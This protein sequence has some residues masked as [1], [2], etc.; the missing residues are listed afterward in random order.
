VG[1]AD[2][3][4][5]MTISASAQVSDTTGYIAYN[6]NSSG[7]VVVDGTGSSWTNGTLYVGANGT[8]ALEITAGAQ[9]NSAL[10]FIGD[11]GYGTVTIDGAGS[12]WT[13][14]QL[15]IGN[16]GSATLYLTHGGALVSTGGPSLGSNLGVAT[17]IVDGVGS[18]WSNGGGL[19][20]ANDSTLSITGGASVN[21]T[22]GGASIGVGQVFNAS[23]TVDGA[24]STWTISG[25]VNLGSSTGTGTLTVRNGGLVS[26]GSP[27]SIG[28]LGT[29]KGDGTI[30]GTVTNGGMVAPGAAIGAL[31]I[32]GNYTQTAAGT[33]A[34]E[35]AGQASFDR[36]LVSGSAALDGTIAVALSGGFT[37]TLGETFSV[38]T[39]SSESGDFATYTG[40]SI[41]DHLTLHHAFLGNSLVL[42]A[43][44]SLDGDINL[45][46]VVNGLDI[47]AVSSHWLQTGSAAINGDVNGD[48]VVNGLDIALISSHWLQTGGAGAGSGAAAPEPSSL[49]LA[50][51][52]AL[53]L[54]AYRR[55]R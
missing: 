6:S 30:S 54:L 29:L 23:A 25:G 28:A 33:L 55:R 26:V 38:L 16:F 45:D 17:V 34:I 53:A 11:N 13:A 20:I 12:T 15:A 19:G 50:A 31:T 35:L 21:T 44:P 5:S 8:G 32:N 22:G 18:T 51:L 3:D 41:G 10:S 1:V 40:L 39:F 14:G 49:V 37:P 42:T 46:G 7:K 43:R 24:G 48:G 52:G 9:V 4:N 27:L 36:L 2:H 47:A